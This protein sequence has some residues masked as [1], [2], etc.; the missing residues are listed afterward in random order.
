MII[1]DLDAVKIVLDKQ[2][3]IGT[4]T[5]QDMV[6][7]PESVNAAYLNHV[8]SFVVL[9]DA[10]SGD[11]GVTVT[12]YAKRLIRTVKDKGA[13]KGYITADYGYGKTSTALFVW[14]Q[15]QAANILTV[16]PF[17]MLHLHD[18]LKATH[19]WLRFVLAQNYPQLVAKA[20]DIY[21]K[22]VNRDIETSGQNDGERQL[23]RRMY[24]EGRYS[25][26]LRPIDY[27][28]FFQEMTDVALEAH[29]DGLVV[30]ADE[31][32]HYIDDLMG[33]GRDPFGPLHDIVQALLVRKNDLAFGLLL[34]VPNRTLV[35]MTAHRGDMV[36][37]F[38]DSRLALDLSTI[39]DQTFARKLW[40][41]MAQTFDFTALQDRIIQPEM[42]DG[43]GQIA[44]RHDL[45][46]GPRTV[47][48]VLQN[49]VRHYIESDGAQPP[50][51][52]LDL[53]ESFLRREVRFDQ[54][55]L[56]QQVITTHLAHNFVQNRPDLQRAIKI[57]AA[58]PTD[59][60]DERLFDSY[61]VR[62]AIALLTQ[63]AQ[64]DIVT[65]G[66]GTYDENGTRR[67]LRALLMGLQRNEVKGDF[68]TLL[69]RE[70]NQS[71]NER[72]NRMRDL[73]LVGFRTLLQER[74]FR[75]PQWKVQRSL[76][77]MMTQNRALIVE[78]AF[79][80]MQGHFP[81]RIIH[82][83]ILGEA[84]RLIDA[85][86][87]GDIALNFRVH[88]YYDMD[89]AARRMFGG[90]VTLD[91]KT[92]TFDLNFNH[93]DE[94]ENY[95][96]LMTTLTP[97]FAPWKLTPALMLSLHAF[98]N[99]RKPKL[100]ATEIQILQDQ[101]QPSLLDHAL[102]ELFNATLGTSVKAA[103]GRIVEEVVRD[104]LVRH[105]PNYTTLITGKT[106]RSTLQTYRSALGKLNVPQER[107][108]QQ[109]WK[110]GQ[111]KDVA[112]L[113]GM[114][115]ASVDTY[116]SSNRALVKTE[117]TDGLRFSLLPL[118]EA[119]I[120]QIKASPSREAPRV[121]G[122]KPRPSILRDAIFTQARIVGYRTIEIEQGLELLE[123]RDLV[124]TDA[125][126]RKLILKTQN[127]PTPDE[128]QQILAE[129]QARLKTVKP[130]LPRSER[131]AEWQRDCDGYANLIIGFRR[132][133]D[134]GKQ[135]TLA[136]AIRQRARSLT[137]LIGDEKVRMLEQTKKWESSVVL[138]PLRPATLD[139][140]QP[141]ELFG[142]QLDAQRR[143]LQNEIERAAETSASLRTRVSALSAQLDKEP[144][145]DADFVRGMQEFT[146][147]QKAVYEQEGKQARLKD[148]IGAYDSA[149]QVLGQARTFAARL[150]NAPPHLADTAR[151]ALK[152]W[153]ERDVSGDLSSHKLDG[154]ALSRNWRTALNTIE[155]GFEDAQHTERN[156]FADK[157][158][159]FKAYL[160]DA[161]PHDTGWK[162]ESYNPLAPTTSYAQ[163]WAQIHGV[164]TRAVETA[165]TRLQTAYDRATR[166]QSG[167]GNVPPDERATLATDLNTQ[168]TRLKQAVDAANKW[169]VQLAD[170]GFIQKARERGEAAAPDVALRQVV[171]NIKLL[172]EKLPQW[173][174]EVAETERR[175]TERALSPD[176]EQAMAALRAL[177]AEAGY[178]D[179]IEL[180]LW[181][182]RLGVDRNTAWMLVAQ[183][184]SK[185]RLR[186][187]VAP[188]DF[189][190]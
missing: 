144:L 17:Q 146:A 49:V 61:G 105:Y 67:P 41:Q 149:T 72:A 20:D 98:L 26:D 161:F 184:Y 135:T 4:W 42:L 173:E 18:L 31:I 53:A 178:G 102:S 128:L 125:T 123:A 39:Y 15:C 167:I 97:I 73:T 71:Y 130:A 10:A 76:G 112:E 134:E 114:S 111:K 101:F 3:I 34:T 129:F 77:H 188:V 132:T 119:I 116:M 137:L 25:L 50:Y 33:K 121:P 109:I 160:Y 90:A 60:L 29:F 162:D 69:L 158:R 75:S 122:E 36:Q 38:K 65:F 62:D 92:A 47:V 91:D 70:F 14:Q 2:P 126:K 164:F 181:L 89:E 81:E 142:A 24:D 163:L 168:S 79:G 56:L 12:D 19:G 108:G 88:L 64:G 55:A 179:E 147:L 127:V 117:G 155:R 68:L 87:D 165:R 16:P 78:G 159:A 190:G 182:A 54:T 74:I 186:L 120:A 95:S 103:G 52:P 44:A 22:Y 40:A 151:A 176:E 5:A 133:P 131:V 107:Q 84:D 48:D 152:S 180:Q 106:W 45:A 35:Q 30:I 187:K 136:L 37:R 7:R 27:I 86:I 51:S 100:S 113:F 59:G 140:P 66:G 93:H 9:G 11:D 83:R 57:M 145:L 141:S 143:S 139:Q 174:A 170:P 58:F 6:A 172:T 138:Y 82:A 124:E 1:E 43:L 156:A 115:G 104:L 148:L 80:S 189:D 169:A 96:D 32:Q 118:E 157:H 110:Y 183:L 154:L 28:Y 150:N 153:A 85:Q 99:E 8:R 21:T 171:A 175:I 63:E 177:V 23:L 185:Q 166:L 46:N 13:A 94:S